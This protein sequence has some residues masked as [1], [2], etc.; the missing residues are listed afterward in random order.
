MCPWIVFFFNYLGKCRV[1]PWSTWFLEITQKYHLCVSF[2]LGI[3]TLKFWLSLW[4]TPSLFFKKNPFS[5]P[6]PTQVQGLF[7]GC[8]QMGGGS[9][10]PPTLPKFLNDETWQSC[11]LHKEN[12]KTRKIMCH[13]PWVL[14][15]SAFFYRKSATFVISKN[16]FVD[17]IL[18]YSLLTFFQS[19]K[20]VF[21]NMVAILMKSAKLAILGLLKSVLK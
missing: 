1:G 7:R 18:T 19:L 10:K 11:M 9:K 4:A 14:L 8:S 15:T 20:V 5:S 12:R 3:P 21:I 6:N 2:R 16:T 13:N 17:W